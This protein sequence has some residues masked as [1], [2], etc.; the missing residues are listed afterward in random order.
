MHTKVGSLEPSK[1]A[2]VLIMDVPDYKHIGYRFGT[3]LI[4]KVIKAGR[5]VA[6]K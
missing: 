1:Q 4:K 5:V 2:D 3:N 6:E